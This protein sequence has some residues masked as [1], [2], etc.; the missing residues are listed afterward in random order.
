MSVLQ[1]Y[2]S[3]RG[4]LDS[5]IGTAL[6]DSVAD[7]L[8]RKIQQKAMEN[9][10]SFQATPDAKRKRRKTENSGLI[11]DAMM[12]T[13]VDG[14][15]LTLEN[16]AEPQHASGIELTPIVEEGW[17]SWNQPGP[18]RFMDEARNEYVDSGEADRDIANDL[19]AMGFTVL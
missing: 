18:R 6:G 5:A 7:G 2:A 3:I 10:Y 17:G 9:V 16:T 8:K 11:D 4:L 12:I 19:R 1:D 14:M 15:T 13:M